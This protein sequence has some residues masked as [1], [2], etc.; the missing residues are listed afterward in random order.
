LQLAQLVGV[1]AYTISGNQVPDMLGK[2]AEAEVDYK[3]E[4][5]EIKQKLAGIESLGR[6]IRTFVAIVAGAAVVIVAI[7]LFW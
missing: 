1:K 6:S 2:K 3:A 4:L 5:V 7:A